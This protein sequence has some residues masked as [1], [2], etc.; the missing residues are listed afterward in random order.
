MWLKRLKLASHQSRI[1]CCKWAFHTWVKPC[2]CFS[3]TEPFIRHRFSAMVYFVPLL[4]VS[5][6][7]QWKWTLAQ[8]PL[9]LQ[10]MLH[11]Y[12]L[13]YCRI[14]TSHLACSIPG[15]KCSFL[16]VIFALHLIILQ[17]K[18]QIGLKLIHMES[19]WVLF[20]QLCNNKKKISSN[21]M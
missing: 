4:P 7:L 6:I 20:S 5:Q 15:I 17:T 10:F 16:N 12:V 9:H 14:S 21:Y 19:L 11:A 13:L 18:Y 8:T 3:Q 1:H 2:V